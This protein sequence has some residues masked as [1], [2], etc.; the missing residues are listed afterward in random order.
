[1]YVWEADS[2]S[3]TIVYG[4]ALSPEERKD[5]KIISPL[6][7]LCLERSERDGWQIFYVQKCRLSFGDV[8]TELGDVDPRAFRFFLSISK[9]AYFELTGE[10]ASRTLG[11]LFRAI[12][13]GK[14]GTSSNL[15]PSYSILQYT[16]G[17]DINSP[18]MMLVV[19]SSER[20]RRLLIGHRRCKENEIEKYLSR[21][22]VVP[23]HLSIS[24]TFYDCKTLLEQKMKKE[25]GECRWS[26]RFLQ[27]SR[28]KSQRRRGRQSR[29]T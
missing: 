2:G 1:M 27:A 12:G 20:N 22:T 14:A 13:L 15:E 11:K 18:A 24:R 29:L 28:L 3:L 16:P 23:I 17:I 10:V 21:L 9:N 4:V 5:E 7:S 25:F 6:S 8:L 26:P 19:D